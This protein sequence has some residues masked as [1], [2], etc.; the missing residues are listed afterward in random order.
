[1]TDQPTLTDDTVTL[2]P[3]RD[4]DVA[5]AVAGHDELI[6]HWFGSDVVTPSHETHA[7]A[8]ERWRSGWAEGRVAN[9]VIDHDGDVVGSCEV[10]RVDDHSGELSWTLYAGHRGRGYA[11]RAVR[12][13][14][15][16]ATTPAGQAGWGLSR[17]EA[18]VEPDNE[19]SL[20]VATRSGL[21]REGVR[22]V[23]AGTGD[24]AETTEYVVLARLADDPPIADPTGFRS[25]LNSFLPR[26][27]AISQM[28]VRD[29]DERVLLCQLT[30]KR[31]GICPAASSRSASRRS[32]PWSGRSRRSSACGRRPAT[33]S[34]PTGSR[35]G[36][37]GTTPS[38]WSSTAGCTTPEVADEIVKQARE[39]RRRSS[40]R[41]RRSASAAPTSPRAGSRRHCP[42]WAARRPT[43]SRPLTPPPPPA[44]DDF[45]SKITHVTSY[46]FDFAEGNRDQRD[47]LGGKGANLAEMTN[48]GCRCRPGSRSPP[49]RAA[50]TSSRAGSPTASPTRSTATSAPWRRRWVASSGTP[51][52]RCSCRSAR[53]RSSRCPG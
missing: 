29:P 33:C 15:D 21:R 5:A 53:E 27:R 1:M 16:W 41:P 17:V 25:L 40:A 3:W 50:P 23:V 7:Q 39:I 24:R 9:F 46:V 37:A 45:G 42:T 30:Y 35:R 47:L 31:T 49:R 11:T 22:R 32:S 6:A 26:K 18:K 12:M 48:L 13:L 51:P 10:R 36:A 19:A 52:T 20:R 43:P 28:L 38:A 4:A 8:V 34:S 14:A 2:R 44:E